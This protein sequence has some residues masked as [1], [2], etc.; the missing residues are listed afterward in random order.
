MVTGYSSPRKLIHLLNQKAGAGAWD[1]AYLTHFPGKVMLL[2]ARGLQAGLADFGFQIPVVSI[3]LSRCAVR[4][5]VIGTFWCCSGGRLERSRVLRCCLPG[6][7][8]GAFQD[9]NAGSRHIKRTENGFTGIKTCGEH[10][11][12]SYYLCPAK[13]DLNKLMAQMISHRCIVNIL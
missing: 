2:K 4:E 6:K 8:N 10:L 1:S 12:S 3:P 7:V 9:R 13:W 5:K 11:F